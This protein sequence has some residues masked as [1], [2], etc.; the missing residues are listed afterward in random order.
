MFENLKEMERREGTGID[1]SVRCGKLITRVRLDARGG[2]LAEPKGTTSTV[3]QSKCQFGDDHFTERPA[4]LDSQRRYRPPSS[5]RPPPFPPQ[6]AVMLTGPL[7]TI[8]CPHLH[9]WLPQSPFPNPDRQ[10]ALS[11]WPPTLT[12]T[13]TPNPPG[14][15]VAVQRR[16]P[17]T[18]RAPPIRN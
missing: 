11:G 6:M 17:P 2:P 13:P 1:R 15:H 14:L 4:C 16:R 9:I 8:P 12:P 10:S 5:P 3:C 18:T 7:I